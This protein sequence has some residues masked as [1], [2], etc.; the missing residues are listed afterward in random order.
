[1]TKKSSNPNLTFGAFHLPFE[2]GCRLISI[3]NHMISCA[4]WNKLGTGHKV[5]G[6]G[7]VGYEKLG[8]GHYF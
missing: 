1:M 6:G 2:E 8:V 7:G 4:I 5:R 3:G